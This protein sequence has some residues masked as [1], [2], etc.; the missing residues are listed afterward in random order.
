MGQG[1][2]RPARRLARRLLRRPDGRGVVAEPNPDRPRTL[3]DFR[4]F[5]VLGTWME[6]DVVEATV[7]NAFAQGVEAVFLVDNASTDQTVARA[8]AAGAVLA[9][10]FRTQVYEEHVRV[11]LMSGVVA[12]ESLRCE[13]DHV[14]WLYLDADEFPEG[15]D[16]MTIREYLATLD[17]RFRLVGSTYYN[18]FPGA[19][20]QNLPG[21]HPTD[22]QPLC[23]RY[24]RER[25][26]FCAQDHFKH[27]L[28]RYDLGGPFVMSFIGFHS[29]NTLARTP[30]LEPVGGIVTHHMQYRDEAVTRRRLELLCGGGERNAHNDSLGNTAIRKRFESLDAVYAQRWDEVDNLRVREANSGVAPSPW[31]GPLG[32]RWYTPADLERARRRWQ[33]SEVSAATP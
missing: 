31:P 33:E 11:L 17:A 4:F 23:E 5:A 16:G 27:P 30:L 10:S 8:E 3:P 12:R 26:T 9:E 6:D 22:L 7:R 21:F 14:W 13:A 25:P 24:V 19:A 29:A 15:P 20:P 28:Q 2:A 32:P 18:H 1:L